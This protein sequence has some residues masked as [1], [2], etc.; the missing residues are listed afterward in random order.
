MIV[1][2]T[3]EGV[4]RWNSNMLR[5]A[6]GKGGFIN[7]DLKR[8]GD[9]KSPVGEWPFRFAYFRPDRV[10]PPQTTLPIIPI[11]REL[12]WCDDP[13]D[14]NYNRPVIHPYPASAENLW[15]DDEL[16]DVVVVLGHNDDPVVSGAGSAIFLHCA[17]PDFAPTEGCIALQRQ[18][19]LELLANSAPGDSLAILGD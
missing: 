8:E 2:V 14:P 1:T 18:D 16:Y 5:A 4:L 9:G 12:G 7:A 13:K 19:L 3:K 15:R 10:D 6:I 11:T 17:Q